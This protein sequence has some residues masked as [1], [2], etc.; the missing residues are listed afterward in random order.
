MGEG[1]LSGCL[2]S[3]PSGKVVHSEPFVA[4]GPQRKWAV[5]LFEEVGWET[6]PCACL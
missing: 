5:L 6:S 3:V 2:V 1:R 4:L